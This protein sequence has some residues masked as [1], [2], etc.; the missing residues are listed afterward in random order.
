MKSFL[1]SF[2]LFYLISCKKDATNDLQNELNGTW[3]LRKIEYGYSVQP[4]T[5]YPANNENTISF[6][7]TNQYSL[8]N[9]TDGNKTTASGTYTISKGTT[10]YSSDVSF[11]KFSNDGVDNASILE[12]FGD[13]LNLYTNSCIIADGVD[14]TYVKIK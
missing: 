5:I 12:L 3:E 1:I 13:T 4:D 6:S 11:I 2:A 9:V 8:N 7:G 10:C 14:K